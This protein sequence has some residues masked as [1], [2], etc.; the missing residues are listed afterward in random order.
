MDWVNQEL[1]EGG[2][3]KQTLAV[4]DQGIL[5]PG[6]PEEGLVYIDRGDITATMAEVASKFASLKLKKEHREA[7][8]WLALG[9]L[10]LFALLASQKK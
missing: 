8:G 9:S 7:V 3:G 6:F 2:R 4:I 1:N 5:V 10:L